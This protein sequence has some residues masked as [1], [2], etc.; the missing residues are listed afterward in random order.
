ME[1]TDPVM[2]E[3]LCSVV[4][5]TRNRRELLEE[6]VRSVLEQRRVSVECVIVDDGSDEPLERWDDP[7]VRVV[8]HEVPRGPAAAR[9]TGLR[10]AR[11]RYVSF[12]DDDD[13]YL[14]TRLASATEHIGPGIA[15]VCWSRAMG[16][17]ARRGRLLYGDE[18]DH[19]FDEA[20][21]QIGTITLWRDGCPEFDEGLPL[22]EDVEWWLRVAEKY[23]FLTVPMH[24]HLFREHEGPRITDRHLARLTA[25]WQLIEMQADYF[26]SHPRALAFRLRRMGLIAVGAGLDGEAVAYFGRSFLVRPGIRP[27]AHLL[28]ALRRATIRKVI[29]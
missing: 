19:I 15:V 25:S 1:T 11:G 23:R 12:L 24:L 16:G 8:G 10:H 29:S 2:S 28:R 4:I 14:P 9:N 20:T 5:P 3:D 13:R 22:N 26:A 17:T 6:A 18:F 7:R 27:A 21:P